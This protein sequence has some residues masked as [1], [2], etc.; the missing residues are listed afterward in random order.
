MEKPRRCMARGTPGLRLLAAPRLARAARAG[1]RPGDH[2]SVPAGSA[3][4]GRRVA[5]SAGQDGD[6]RLRC[7]RRNLRRG[8]SRR[9]VA[10]SSAFGIGSASF[11]VSG[12]HPGG[13]RRLCPTTS[14]VDG[15]RDCRYDAE[16]RIRTV[17]GTGPTA[18]RDP[19][20]RPRCVFR[21]R[22]A[23][24]PSGGRWFRAG[25]RCGGSFL[26]R[27]EIPLMRGVR[28]SPKKAN[29]SSATASPALCEKTSAIR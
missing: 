1:H 9:G 4:E 20:E 11:C 3:C 6:A 29:L 16:P 8:L 22:F 26:H 28:K 23:P 18:R 19:S 25:R 7:G 12:Q 17:A 5:R 15:P 10:G 14:P 13:R 2:F 21:S 24:L 27:L